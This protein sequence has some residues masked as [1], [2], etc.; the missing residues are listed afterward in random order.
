MEGRIR[1][2]ATVRA[3]QGIVGELTVQHLL[4]GT[5]AYHCLPMPYHASALVRS[6]CHWETQYLFA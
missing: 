4:A 3:Y 6:Q 1:G 2:R 5:Q